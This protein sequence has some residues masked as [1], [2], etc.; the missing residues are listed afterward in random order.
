MAHV[1]LQFSGFTR[2]IGDVIDR[3]S[4]EKELLDALANDTCRCWGAAMYASQELGCWEITDPDFSEEDDELKEYLF[5]VHPV[6]AEDECEILV[7]RAQVSVGSSPSA[8]SLTVAGDGSGTLTIGDLKVQFSREEFPRVAEGILKHIDMLR[9]FATEEH[10][11]SA[12][13]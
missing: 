1:S 2:S 7:R 12:E 11:R 9:F 8:V 5:Q 13:D 4:G 10:M 3:T 6:H